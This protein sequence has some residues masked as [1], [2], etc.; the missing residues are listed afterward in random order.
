MSSWSGQRSAN[1][2]SARKASSTFPD[3]CIR[4]AY[5]RKFCLASLVKPF[6]ALILPSL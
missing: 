2:F 1:S 4:S 6:F 5:S 3:F